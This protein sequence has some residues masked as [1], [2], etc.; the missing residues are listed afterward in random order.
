MVSNFNFGWTNP[1]ESTLCWGWWL[2]PTS[3]QQQ[4]DEISLSIMT[5]TYPWDIF[6]IHIWY[7]NNCKEWLKKEQ[8]LNPQRNICFCF[9]LFSFQ[10]EM[11]GKRS[12]FSTPQP[13]AKWKREIIYRASLYF[14]VSQQLSPW[15][16]HPMLPVAHFDI[17][18]L[19]CI[20]PAEHRAEN[21]VWTWQAQ[22]DAE[23]WA[24]NEDDRVSAWENEQQQRVGMALGFYVRGSV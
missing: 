13:A 21:T 7:L 5:S 23:E 12:S 24:F 9:L 19:I 10:G 8:L 15:S 16:I 4:M 18:F 3:Q 11:Q 1:L 17:L 22:G 14:S 6:L 20:N 2:E